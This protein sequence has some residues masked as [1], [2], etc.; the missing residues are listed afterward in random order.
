M[1]RFL[2]C[3]QPL[4]M[5]WDDRGVFPAKLQPPE[6]SFLPEADVNAIKDF[7]GNTASPVFFSLAAV[8]II[9]LTQDLTYQSEIRTAVFPFADYQYLH[10]KIVTNPAARTASSSRVAFQIIANLWF[11]LKIKPGSRCPFSLRGRRTGMDTFLNKHL[12]RQQNYV[13]SNTKTDSHKLVQNLDIQ[14][15][16]QVCVVSLACAMNLSI[17][18]NINVAFAAAFPHHYRHHHYRYRLNGRLDLL[19]F[20]LNLH[21]IS[22]APSLEN[23]YHIILTFI[24]D[25]IVDDDYY[26]DERS[27]SNVNDTDDSFCWLVV[28][29]MDTSLSRRLFIE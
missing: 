27:Y 7:I 18:I 9:L 16:Q 5:L 26:D 6:L 21:F 10:S 4:S 24:H 3:L 29:C 11:Q 15:Y 2:N 20:I 22:N 14:E 8:I 28:F 1:H 25:D 13:A 12:S 19:V 17:L 23:S